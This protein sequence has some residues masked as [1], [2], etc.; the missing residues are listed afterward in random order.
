MNRN[1]FEF[2]LDELKLQ[3]NFSII[4]VNH[5]N[6]QWQKIG[7]T[8][9]SEEERTIVNYEFWYYLQNY[10]ISLANISKLLYSV[11]NKYDS[12]ETNATRRQ[13]RQ[14]FRVTIGVDDRSILKDKKMRN[15]LEHIDENI[16]LFADN[17]PNIIVNRGIGPVNM[18]GVNEESLFENDINNLR[19]F[20]TDKKELILF[21]R[22]INIES[23]FSEVMILKD[24]VVET[25]NKF[26]RGDLNDLFTESP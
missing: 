1:R 5:F 26:K 17:K 3:T 8:S 25:E 7:N 24:K 18:I 23:T 15:T 9:L 11:Y 16:E 21:G 22:R 13:E 10:V 6:D 14:F 20:L 19:N 4:S 12:K 2:L